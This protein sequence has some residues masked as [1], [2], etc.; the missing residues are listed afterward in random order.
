MSI[1]PSISNDFIPYLKLLL[2]APSPK[3]YLFIYLLVILKSRS[4]TETILLNLLLKEERIPTYRLFFLTKRGK[5]AQIF[6]LN[7]Y[8]LI[9][10]DSKKILPPVLSY[11]FEQGRKKRDR[12]CQ[13]QEREV[14]REDGKEKLKTEQKKHFTQFPIIAID[15]CLLLALGREKNADI[16]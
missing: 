14:G 15:C 3:I 9:I 10:T 12:A 6:N 7:Y 13:K 4:K 1:V 8:L 16:L 2:I 5:G 11:L